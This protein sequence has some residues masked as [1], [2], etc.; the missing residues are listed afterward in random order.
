MELNT[1]ITIVK[2]NWYLT[3]IVVFWL[4]FAYKYLNLWYEILKNKYL[5]DEIH[6]ENKSL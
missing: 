3:I 6:W 4:F 5:K 1:I 2:D